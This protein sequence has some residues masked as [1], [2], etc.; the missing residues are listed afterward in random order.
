MAC[1]VRCRFPLIAEPVFDQIRPLFDQ[2]S[3]IVIAE[4]VTS[5]PDIADVVIANPV[6]TEPVV[7][8]PGIDTPVF[9][10]YLTSIC[11]FPAIDRRLTSV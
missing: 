4:P 11:A 3:T 1:G 6:I 2:H 7:T 10:Q 5:H 9:D 8:D